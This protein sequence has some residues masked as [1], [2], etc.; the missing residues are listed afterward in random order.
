ML[1]EHP[2]YKGAVKSNLFNLNLCSFRNL[3]PDV[4]IREGNYLFE[5][6]ENNVFFTFLTRLLFGSKDVPSC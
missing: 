2:Y 5:F 6:N 1:L 3:G 4:Y